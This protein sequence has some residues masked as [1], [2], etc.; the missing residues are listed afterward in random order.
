[1][2]LALTKILTHQQV[3]QAAATASSCRL[4]VLGVFQ[5]QGNLKSSDLTKN[6]VYQVEDS[7]WE[8]ETKTD[9][10]RIPIEIDTRMLV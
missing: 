9:I 7:H 10:A 6:P 3:H 1:M 5:V 8:E 2:M 4:L